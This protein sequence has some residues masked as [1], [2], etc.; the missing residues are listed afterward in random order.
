MT[1]STVLPP[2]EGRA[3]ARAVGGRPI[4]GN[5]VR[6]L[7]DGPETYAVML[8]SIARAERW[9]HFENYIIRSDTTGWRFAEALAERARAGVR[10]RVLYDWFGSIG[11]S[12]GYWRFLRKAGVDVRR[13]HP[14]RLVD[15]FVNAQRNHRKLVVVDGREAVTG[16]LCIGD[17]WAGE[18][19]RG[20]LPWRDTAVGVIGPAVAALD[21]SFADAWRRAGDGQIPEQERLPDVPPAGEAGVYVV[22]G[23]PGRGRVYRLLELL[24]AGSVERL[25]ITDAYMAAPPQLYYALMEAA[26]DGVDVRLLLPGSSDLPVLRNI[27]R[28]G[29]R[30]LLRA[31]IRIYEWAGP[32]LHAKTF[33]ADRRL[34]RV[35]SSNLNVSSLIGN[36]ELD[37]L[38]DDPVFVNALEAQF[39]RD[40]ARSAEI[41]RRIPWAPTGLRRMLPSALDREPP[42]QPAEP[43]RPSRRERRSRV[44]LTLRAVAT[45]AHRSL[46]GP[47]SLTLL[48]LGGAFLAAPQITAYI[49]GGLCFWL[50]VAVGIEALRRRGE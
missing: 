4:P 49:F 3:I 39:Q 15:L 2:A 28:I 50:A 45:A 18:P 26:R 48:L 24:T 42:V 20:V 17:E 34:A 31:G 10:V 35:G 37:V 7:L 30:D 33:I 25:W 38:V 46:Y 1:V 19:T 12:G 44:V 36:F 13:F 5:A 32:M 43:S 16:G 23:Q 29:Y 21:Q 9:V 47:L 6:L 27:T 41:E 22:A 40:I 11:T 14:P 8:E